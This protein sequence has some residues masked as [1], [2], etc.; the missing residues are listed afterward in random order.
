MPLHHPHAF[1]Q[2]V[3]QPYSPQ[4]HP[5]AHPQDFYPIFYPSY[6]STLEMR[7]LQHIADPYRQHLYPSHSSHDMHFDHISSSSI[8]STSMQESIVSS[9]PASRLDPIVEE[10]SSA[11]SSSV[12]SN[13][14][15][16]TDSSPLTMPVSFSES[17]SYLAPNVEGTI[18]SALVSFSHDSSDP[19]VTS[20]PLIEEETSSLTIAS[21]SIAATPTAKSIVYSKPR[22]SLL[23]RNL[24][25]KI[26]ETED[27]CSFL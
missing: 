5:Y 19:T 2:L 10:V 17:T 9:E 18:S 14:P 26:Q 3:E 16:L 22:R 25:K 23:L 13:P 11:T 12:C 24:S 27:H 8:R 15:Q 21:V 7:E 4:M 6:D 1:P 20:Q